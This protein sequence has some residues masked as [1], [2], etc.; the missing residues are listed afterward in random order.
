M[1]KIIKKKL[2]EILDKDCNN[3]K[4]KLSINDLEKF[5]KKYGILVPEEYKEFLTSYYS[6]YVNDDYYYPMIEKSKL[7]PEDGMEVIDY[8]YNLEF[9]SNVDNF[10]AI[11]GDR[12]LPIGCAAGDF[13]CIGIQKEN[14]NKIYH[15]YHEDEDRTNGLYLAANSFN[16]FIL[17][18]KY[19]ESDDDDI[20][21]VITWNL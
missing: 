19:I 11:W 20:Q 13:I 3:S 2:N 9:I 12:V 7:T 6:C 15:L 18:F 10:I 1:D 14:F 16:E 21:C 5:E 4:K 8:F 17:S